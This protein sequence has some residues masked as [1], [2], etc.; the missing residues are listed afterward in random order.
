MQS[1]DAPLKSQFSEVARNTWPWEANLEFTFELST[2][3]LPLSGCIATIINSL[4]LLTTA[5]C[6]HFGKTVITA[7]RLL[8]RFGAA[9][10]GELIYK[11][12]RV[13]IHPD[14][15]KEGMK[16]QADI[17]LIKLAKQIK[18]SYLL[19][20]ICINQNIT[21]V[22]GDAGF[23]I[24]R[25]RLDEMRYI[26]AEYLLLNNCISRAFF[27]TVHQLILLLLLLMPLLLLLRRVL[28]LLIIL[29]LLLLLLSLLLFLIL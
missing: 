22:M 2:F 1:F 18:P 21:S 25:G 5:H 26:R 16:I 15:Y 8:V 10:A 27:F 13:L 24:T 11:A 29:L 20:P 4:Y 3:K 6:L 17:G 19:H 28:L 9:G 12:E 23:L 7:S 14:Y